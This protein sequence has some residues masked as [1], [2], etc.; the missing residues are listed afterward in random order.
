LG[1]TACTEGLPSGPQ[2]NST[3]LRPSRHQ[4][5]LWR[6]KLT[7]D[8]VD[9]SQGKHCC[10]LLIISVKVR[11]VVTATSLCEHADDDTVET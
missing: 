11:D 6:G 7:T 8:A 4:P 5:H 9:R 1:E 3:Q 2:F 10:V